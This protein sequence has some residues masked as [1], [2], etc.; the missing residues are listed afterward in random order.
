MVSS[1]LK[2]SLSALKVAPCIESKV[3]LDRI[4]SNMINVRPTLTWLKLIRHI[5][6]LTLGADRVYQ[7]GFY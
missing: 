4:L 2:V 1:S 7:P 3:A 6:D 5:F